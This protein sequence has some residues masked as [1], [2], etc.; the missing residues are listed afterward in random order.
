VIRGIESVLTQAGWSLLLTVLRDLGQ[1]ATFRRLMRISGQV[2]GLLIA[3]GIISSPCSQPA[4][5]SWSS[6]VPRARLTPT[7][8]PPTTA[9]APRPWSGT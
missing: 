3:E 4:S 6:P 5:P 1:D 7:S 2:D 8:S 9:P